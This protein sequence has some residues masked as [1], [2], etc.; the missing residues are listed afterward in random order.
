MFFS[1]FTSFFKTEYFRQ[2]RTLILLL[3]AWLFRL[4]FLLQGNYGSVAINKYVFLQIGLILALFFIMV[5]RNFYPS[6][7]FLSPSTRPFAFIYFLGMVSILWSVLPLMS[8]FFAFENLVC[9][10]VLL[11][12][13]LRCKDKFQLERFFIGMVIAILLM[14][15][16]RQCLLGGFYFHSVSYSTVAAMLTTYCLGEW[17]K[18]NR[19]RENI[20]SLKMGLAFGAG[21]LILTTSG[22]AIFS[23]FLSCL[24]LVLF[25]RNLSIRFLTFIFLCVFAYMWF[26]GNTDAVLSLLFPGKSMASIASAHGRAY[27]WEMIYEKIAERPWLGWGYAAVERVLPLYCVDAHNSLIGIRGS[28]GNVGFAGLIIAMLLQLLYLFKHSGHFGFKGLLV[29]TVCAFINS[30]TTNFLASKAGASALTF[31]LLLVLGTVYSYFVV[32]ETASPRNVDNGIIINTSN[33]PAK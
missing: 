19:P 22:G 26:S 4:C 14:F 9:M 23:A 15:F 27:V 7:L 6:Q 13:G 5:S 20:T 28:L 24:V 2:N 25:A 30:N 1:Y 12:L 3:F 8:C 10:T 29:A 16:S 21:F 17:G 11:Y 18:S 33:I 31:Q 32:R